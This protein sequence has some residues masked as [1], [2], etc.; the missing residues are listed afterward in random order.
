[1]AWSLTELVKKI[2]TVSENLVLF[3]QPLT[4]VSANQMSVHICIFV[5]VTAS[6]VSYVFHFF[7]PSEE[8]RVLIRHEWVRKCDK[9]D[10]FASHWK[11]WCLTNYG[12]M[13]HILRHHYHRLANG[14]YHSLCGHTNHQ[15]PAAIHQH[16]LHTLLGSFWS[17]NNLSGDAIWLRDNHF[18]QAL[19]TWWD[20]VQCMDDNVLICC[21]HVHSKLV[22]FDSLSIPTPSRTSGHLQGIATDDSQA[23][24]YSR[25]LFMGI[26]RALF[27]RPSLWLETASKKCLSW[28]LSF[29]HLFNLFGVKFVDKFCDTSFNR[30]LSELQN[31]LR[32]SQADACSKNWP[33]NWKN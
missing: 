7:R 26:L 33:Q 27:T 17:D 21:T 6:N 16:V 22:G 8:K 30:F 13:F 3:M 20:H 15:I 32:C 4:L 31:V 5:I 23:R 14:K 25:L 18:I 29:Q 11:S 10:C 12:H 9:L 1:M 28:I 2:K 19:E 24:L